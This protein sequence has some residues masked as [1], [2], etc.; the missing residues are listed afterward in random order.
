[1]STEQLH[2]LDVSGFVDAHLQNDAAL[3]TSL[4]RQRRINGIDLLD[5]ES[6][7]DAFRDANALRHGLTS[8]ERHNANQ[9]QT[10]RCR[11]QCHANLRKRIETRSPEYSDSITFRFV[12]RFVS[13]ILQS[14][15]A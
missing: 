6:L 14:R 15:P 1:M 13:R 2:T 11:T 9:E 5:D 4:P 7:S 12:P 3:N 10:R 8:R